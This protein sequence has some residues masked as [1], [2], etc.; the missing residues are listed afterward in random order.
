M[1]AMSH[2]GGL[3]IAMRGKGCVAIAADR[4]LGVGTQT[5]AFD[6]QKIYEMGPHL[7]IGL[8]G[9]ATD[10]ITVAQRLKF[11]LNMYELRENRRIRPKTFSALVSNLQYEKRFGP[12]YVE[13]IIAG[14]DPKTGE[15]FIAGMDVI[16]NTE[17]AKDF[18]LAG[19]SDNQAYGMCETLWR[20]DLEPDELFEVISQSLIN[21]F[22]RDAISGWGGIVYIIEKDKVT[23]KTLKTRMD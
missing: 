15:S 6:F 12:Y 19:T 17:L 18:V 11:R 1:G 8:P 23:V 22:D 5:V 13:P 16:G 4:R 2:N 21:A 10:T 20:P 9:L 7:Y 3:V 14:L